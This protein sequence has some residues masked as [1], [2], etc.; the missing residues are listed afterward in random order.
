MPKEE[1]D[2]KGKLIG[3]VTNPD[4][5]LAWPISMIPLA[6][7]GLMLAIRIWHAMPK[8]HAPAKQAARV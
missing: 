1:F 5:W 2:A 4:N 8:S 7:I 6:L 3:P